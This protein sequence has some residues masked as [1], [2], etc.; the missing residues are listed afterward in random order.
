MKI[1]GYCGAK[2]VPEKKAIVL[3]PLESDLPLVQK[4]FAAKDR[5]EAKEGSAA[6][7]EF[8]LEIGARGHTW[9]QQKAV[10]ALITIIYQSMHGVKPNNDEKYELYLDCLDLYAEKTP[11]RFTGAL[12]AVHL[13]ESDVMQCAGFIGHLMS[14]LVEYCDL[15]MSDENGQKLNLDANVRTVFYRWHLWRGEQ[16]MDPLD[17]DVDGNLLSEAA[18]R[19]KHKVSDASG[20]GGALQLAHIVS[21]GSNARAIDKSWNWLALTYEE[22]QYQ[23]QHGWEVFLRNYPHLK[24]RFLR[25]RSLASKE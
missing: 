24:G 4:L 9:K 13:S 16:A 11:N 21:R 6:Y 8:S 10:W 22:H 17:I 3:Y 19:E 20:V 14:V 23:H 2:Y 7:P 15:D 18:W 12:R 1:S 25:A 5:R